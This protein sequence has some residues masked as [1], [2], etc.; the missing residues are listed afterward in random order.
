VRSISATWV[1][2]TFH[3]RGW[4]SLADTHPRARASIHPPVADT[5]SGCIPP[6]RSRP[7][8]RCRHRAA[9]TATLLTLAF[10]RPGAGT[11]RTGR[12]ARG[13]APGRAIVAGHLD[14]SVDFFRS[15]QD[16]GLDVYLAAGGDNQRYTGSGHVVWQIH[17]RNHVRLAKGVVER[18]KLPADAGT[19]LFDGGPAGGTA[20]SAEP[21]DP[22]RR[23]RTL[24]PGT[25]A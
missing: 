2:V 17:D 16:A 19:R 11:S 7:H 23:Y 20:L 8:S 1:I 3:H 25:S 6:D 15:Q 24:G 5:S 14:G 22:R 18:V 12:V 21:L 4:M 10:A 13:L 9:G